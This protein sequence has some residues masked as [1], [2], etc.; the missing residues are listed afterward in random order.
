VG[1]VL[2][3]DGERPDKG[4]VILRGLDGLVGA[5]PDIIVVTGDADAFQRLLARELKREP[6]LHDVPA[7][8]NAAVYNLPRYVDSGVI[9]YPQTLLRWASALTA[10]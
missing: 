5:A 3:A 4:H 7:V 8:R 6:R 1:D 2:V 10:R 9:E